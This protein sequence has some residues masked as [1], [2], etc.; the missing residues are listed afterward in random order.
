MNILQLSALCKT[1]GNDRVFKLLRMTAN[2][3]APPPSQ[4]SLSKDI[5]KLSYFNLP[6]IK[7]SDALISW[8]SY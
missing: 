3:T 8:Q 1:P 6:V 5:S 7:V 4:K 2:G